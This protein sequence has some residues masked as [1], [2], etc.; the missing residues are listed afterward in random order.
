MGF[1]HVFFCAVITH[2]LDKLNAAF[3]DLGLPPIGMRKYRMDQDRYDLMMLMGY[4]SFCNAGGW[5]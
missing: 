2:V 3:K 5:Q 1:F 4:E